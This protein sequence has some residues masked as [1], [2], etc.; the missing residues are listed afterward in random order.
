[1]TGWRLGYAVLATREEALLFEQLNI[2]LVSCVPP[3]I[4]EAAAIAL[5]DPRGCGGG[6]DGARAPRAQGLDRPRPQRGRRHHLPPAARR[7]SSSTWQR[8]VT[9]WELW[10]HIE[11]FPAPGAEMDALRSPPDVLPVSPRSGH[12]GS[13]LIRHRGSRRTALPPAVSATDLTQL[14]EGVERIRSLAPR[15]RSGRDSP[16][17]GAMNRPLL[18]TKTPMFKGTFRNFANECG[19]GETDS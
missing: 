15:T 17:T 14:Q 2:N 16:K 11:T 10:R 5:H 19:V 4:Q 1:M 9:T 13:H 8:C 3:F 7:P 12:H 6:A 18:N